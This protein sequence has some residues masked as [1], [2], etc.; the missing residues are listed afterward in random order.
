MEKRLRI[1]QLSGNK[2]TNRPVQFEITEQTRNS[3]SSW[4]K[5]AELGPRASRDLYTYQPGSMLDQLML[6]SGKLA[7]IPRNTAL[8]LF[9]EPKSL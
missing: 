6:E 2:K 4:I 9:V 8:T 5:R 1:E 3:I 7:L